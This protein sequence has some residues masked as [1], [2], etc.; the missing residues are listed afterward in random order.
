[1]PDGF[2][3][4][5]VDIHNYEER[6]KRAVENVQECPH[7]SARNKAL[8]LK[9][10][11]FKRSQSTSAG[12]CA[13]TLWTLKQFALSDYDKERKKRA[14]AYDFTI[15]RDFEQLTKDDLQRAR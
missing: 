15:M 6:L 8:L 3:V 13:K 9:F 1:L 2:W 10:I 7:I 14:C 11:E 12:R 4:N 5:L